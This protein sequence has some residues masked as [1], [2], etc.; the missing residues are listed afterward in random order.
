[1]SYIIIII[2]LRREIAVKTG[3]AAASAGRVSLKLYFTMR[4]ER[5]V[6]N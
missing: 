4:I 3:A 6:K 1:M 2:L 5:R